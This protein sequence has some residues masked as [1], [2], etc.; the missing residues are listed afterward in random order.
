[1]FWSIHHTHLDQWKWNARNWGRVHKLLEVLVK[2]FEH[3]IKL[4]LCV[5]DI[6]QPETES[7]TILLQVHRQVITQQFCSFSTNKNPINKPQKCCFKSKTSVFTKVK[8]CT[9]GL[10]WLLCTQN[11][12]VW[13]TGLNKFVPFI[14]QLPFKYSS[15]Q[16]F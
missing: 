7:K 5:D 14:F 12:A 6:E 11:Y 4:I 1:M 2:K 8:F 13:F 10:Q 15:M 3:E 9:Q 16:K